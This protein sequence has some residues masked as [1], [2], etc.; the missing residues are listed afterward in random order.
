[1]KKVISFL[2]VLALLAS[3]APAVLA[4][5]SASMSGPSVVRA[6]DVI[7]VS[8]AAGGGIYGGSGTVSYDA[9]QL[10]LQGYSQTVGGSWAVEFNGNNFVFYDNSMASPIGDITTIFTAAFQVN[11]GVAPGTVVS[12]SASGVTLSDG[13]ADTGAGSPTYSVTI[14]EPLSNNCNLATLVVSN[15]SISPGFSVDQTEYYASVPYEVSSLNLTATAEHPGATVSIGDTYLAEAGTTPVKVTVTAETGATKTYVIYVSRPRDPN[16]VESGNCNLS[17][18]WVEGYVLSPGFAVDVTKYYVWLPYETETVAVGATAEDSKASVSV[19]GDVVLE[20]GKAADIPV[21]VTAENGTQQVY[22]V[23]AVR[24]PSPENVEQYLNCPH[25]TEPEP[26]EPPTEPTEPVT[27]PPTEPPTEPTE[28]AP[29][30]EPE[31]DQG[32]AWWIVLLAAVLGIAVG[33]AGGV[34]VMLWLR[35]Q[36]EV[37]ALAEKLLE[38]A[39]AEAPVPEEGE[40]APAG[41]NAEE[42]ESEAQP[43]EEA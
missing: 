34:G 6:G 7:T 18:L 23:T 38:E 16:Y 13:Q 39:S 19:A 15:A 21:T 24:A 42:P 17:N 3:L 26:T 10:T 33:A 22:T 30:E 40:E 5:G 9:S 32:A 8:F 35:K 37:T 25:E 4:A 14:A 27:E 36:K 31:E 29:V 2:I 41:E 1:M 11:G 28:P 12:V 43:E 20:P